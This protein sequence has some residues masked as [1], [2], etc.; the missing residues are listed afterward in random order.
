MGGRP[1]FQEI[2]F[3]PFSIHLISFSFFIYL[4]PLY[5]R[6][7]FPLFQLLMVNPLKKQLKDLSNNAPKTQV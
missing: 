6:F 2:I 4:G 7:R 5:L 1:Y 3:L